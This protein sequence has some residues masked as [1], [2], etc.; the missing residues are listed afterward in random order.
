MYFL[1]C[2]LQVK[3][4]EVVA[5][6]QVSGEKALAL[7]YPSVFNPMKGYTCYCCMLSSPAFACMLI[8]TCT[9]NR[10]VVSDRNKKS[11]HNT[12]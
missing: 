12:H 5:Q 3:T 8:V 9:Y 11:S 1:P 2:L 10:Q 4:P 6:Y 7:Q